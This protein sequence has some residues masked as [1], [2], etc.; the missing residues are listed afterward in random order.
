MET[1]IAI[2]RGINV[3]GKRKVLMDDLKLLCSKIGLLNVR[4][5]IQSG[6]IIFNSS[7][8]NKDIEDQLENAI[9]EKYGFSVPVIV[10]THNELISTINNNP[11]YTSDTDI[12]KLHLTLLKN[13]PKKE[14]I[15]QA[16][17][18]NYNPDL[19]SIENK[20]VFI[21]CEGKYH[22]TKLSN[23]FFEKQLKV[24]AST[25]NWKTILKLLELSNN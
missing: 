5:Y 6:N 9:E 4:T 2:L 11:F 12:N 8:S 1:M 25:R 18:F 20:D 14:G 3:G 19:F 21:Y 23:T 24:Q 22:Q 13:V 16:Q 17:T 15:I 10:R 7:G